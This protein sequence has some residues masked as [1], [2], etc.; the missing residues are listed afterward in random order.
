MHVQG[1][2][3]L[4]SKTET[5]EFH[6]AQ[7]IMNRRVNETENTKRSGLTKKGQMRNT[8]QTVRKRSIKDLGMER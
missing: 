3:I 2:R 6:R 5:N 8:A 4:K 7:Q 1:T